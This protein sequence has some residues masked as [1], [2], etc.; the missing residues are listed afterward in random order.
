M[1]REGVYHLTQSKP[2]RLPDRLTREEAR[3]LLATPN[4]R[5]KTP[6]RN[7]AMMRLLYRGGLRCAEL[8]DLRMRDIDFS[9]GRVKI[10]EGKGKRD[11]VVWVD[12]ET[13]EILRGWKLERWAGPTFF[14]TRTG[15]PV[16]TSEVRRMV[17]RYG[18]R[19]G[20]DRDCH[21]HLLRHTFATELLEDG[22]SIIEVQKLLGHAHISTTAIYL[23]VA[24]EKLASR[25]RDR[26]D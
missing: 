13:L 8:C 15:S 22:F 5:Y 1:A 24:D 25:L 3:A 4:L 26:I 11:R 2:M 21:P 9:D 6:R 14:T 17:K 23:H 7:R 16:Q 10:V 19:A 12:K 20:I 18:L